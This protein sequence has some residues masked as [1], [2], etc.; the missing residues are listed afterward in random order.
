MC[1]DQIIL[2]KIVNEYWE[3][4]FSMGIVLGMTLMYIFKL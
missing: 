4:G 3:N 1:I 2:N